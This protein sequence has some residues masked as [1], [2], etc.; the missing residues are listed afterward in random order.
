M[1]TN[2]VLKSQEPHLSFR[3]V[4]VYAGKVDTFIDDKS[5]QSHYFIRVTGSELTNEQVNKLNNITYPCA[6][7]TVKIKIYFKTRINN[8]LNKILAILFKINS[9]VI[10]MTPSYLLALIIN[11]LL[12]GL[13]NG[14]NSLFFGI[15]A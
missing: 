13:N 5:V 8:R 10:Q 3:R 14:V 7:H 15:F 9:C 2:F 11:D 1:D 6:E 4:G 12:I